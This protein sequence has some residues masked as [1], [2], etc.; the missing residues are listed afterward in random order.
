MDPLVYSSDDEE[1]S[2]GNPRGNWGNKLVKGAQWVRRGK[3]VAWSPGRDDAE[4]EDL[5]R[6]RVK[7]MLPR[8]DRSPSPPLLPHLRSPSPPLV[9]MHPSLSP[10][11]RSY[12]S[13]IM[14]QSVQHSFR[15]PL[16]EDLE[17]A[18]ESLI[19]GEAALRRS[20]GRL[21]QLLSEPEPSQAETTSMQVDGES[22]PP[23][24]DEQAM[25]D[26]TL[27][28]TEPVSKFIVPPA[29]EILEQ[30]ERLQNLQKQNEVIEKNLNTLRDLQ[31]DSREYVERL[32]EIR[33][34]LGG[35]QC[36]RTALWNVLREKAL[37]EMQDTSAVVVE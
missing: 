5:V 36:Q 20:L 22:T 24:Q 26:Q 9:A 1:L 23:I 3:I 31:D 16:L 25:M 8:P 14:D 2:V 33:E 7:K 27:E 15:S 34:S 11:N 21:W 32:E 17:K 13:F 10:Q 4:M 12:T 6:S 19:E 37:A 35:I 29:N 18:T 28:F 30:A